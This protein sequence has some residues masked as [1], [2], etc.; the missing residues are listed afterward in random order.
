MKA[1]L[2]ILLTASL[3]LIST[4]PSA[5]QS[6]I[7]MPVIVAASTIDDIYNPHPFH[8]NAQIIVT[9][10]ESATVDVSE[11]D[12][13]CAGGPEGHSI[14]FNM[15]LTPGTLT[16]DTTGSSFTVSGGTSSNTVIALYE[17]DTGGNFVSIACNDNG[18]GAGVIN[19]FNVTLTGTY[20]VQIAA[21]PGVT[22][23]GAS[24]VTLLATYTAALPV[25]FDE[26]ANARALKIPSLP[27][28]INI[29]SATIGLDEPVDPL[30]VGATVTNTVWFKFTYSTRRLF[31]VAN[32]YTVAGD[33]W[34]SVFEKSGASYV[35]VADILSVSANNLTVLLEPGTYYLRVGMTGE[36]AGTLS[37]FVT[38]TAIALL[39][40]PNF[41]FAAPGT[42]GTAGAAVDLSG[43]TAT[44]ATGGDTVFCNGS[45]QYLC[46]YR[47]TSAG[48][49]E[50]T[51]IKSTVVLNDVKL[52][53]GDVMTLQVQLM[54]SIGTPNLKATFKLVNAVGATQKFTLNIMSSQSASPAMISYIPATFVP[55]KAT[56]ILKNNDTVTGNSIEIDGVL[57][58]A[59]RV[60]E[61]VV[62]AETLKLPLGGDLSS[63]WAEAASPAQK[64]LL[65]VPPA[66][67]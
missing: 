56:L 50:A 38:F 7:R 14:W 41:Q 12:Q 39:N 31:G 60:G 59:L 10:V 2:T 51:Q 67:Q 28:M 22:V 45:P 55:V 44:N 42:E 13:S 37:P 1:R 62:R 21:A 40:H 19:A 58:G 3:A 27:A 20:S 25:A 6:S 57:A 49:T 23:T 36:P 16:L 15:Q 30:L 32:F 53:K 29:G 34:F 65:P 66:A 46:G 48:A 35:P 4:L 63:A 5:A 43:W 54:G 9:G 52:K 8:P 26:P 18:A 17:Q 24:Q 33:M 61:G 64:G 11:P 47:F